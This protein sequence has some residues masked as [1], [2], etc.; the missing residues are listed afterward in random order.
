MATSLNIPIIIL[1]LIGCCIVSFSDIKYGKISNKIVLIYGS[2]PIILNWLNVFFEDKWVNYFINNVIIIFIGILLYAF[3]VWAGGDCKMMIFIALSTPVNQYWDLNGIEYTL[4]YIYAF[5]FS[6][7][8]IYIC[9]DNVKLLCQKKTTIKKYEIIN[10]V[11]NNIYK[12]IRTMIY[13]SAIGQI[14]LICIWP[15]VKLS[16]ALYTIAC[17]IF[18]LVINSIQLFRNKWM[19][20]LIGLLDVIFVF[21]TGNVTINTLWYTYVIV[22]LLMI[23]RAISSKFNYEDVE[24][25][26]VEKGMI[27]SQETSVALQHSRVRGLPGISDETLRSRM[28]AEE[29]DAV[30][31]WGKSK[32]GTSCV[33]IVR[34]IPFAIFITSGLIV[35][36]I[37]GRV[38]F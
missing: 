33:R 24:P 12:Y 4:W 16:A 36:F 35:Y 31:R 9:Y 8:F 34:K 27:L 19:V 18:I 20:A 15:Y 25:S 3:H 6:F 22:L 14:Y 10:A 7:G 26:S 11:K 21:I 2:V 30:R 29:A 13:L 28:T 23:M 5:I 1:L 37:M 38:Y 17:V 32:Y